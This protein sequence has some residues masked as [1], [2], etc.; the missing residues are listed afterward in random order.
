MIKSYFRIAFRSLFRN[1]GFSIKI[2]QACYW[3]D[4]YPADPVVGAGW[5]VLWQVS[6]NTETFTRM[7]HRDFK[8]QI[9]TDWIWCCHGRRHPAGVPEV[10]N[11]VV[12]TTGSRIFLLT[13]IL[14]EKH[15]YT[16]GEHFLMCSHGNLLKNRN[17]ASWC[18]FHR[19]NRVRGK[20]YSQ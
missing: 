11:A 5:E 15:G 4:L 12:T 1:K 10:K 8:N 13:G 3:H 18:V 16:V 7:A 17:G 6:Y 9:F 14:I 19:V 20:G 2:F